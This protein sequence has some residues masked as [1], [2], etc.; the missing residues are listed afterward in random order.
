MD[1]PFKCASC[2]QTQ[3][4]DFAGWKCPLCGGVLDLPAPVQPWTARQDRQAQVGAL[5]AFDPQRID[6]RERGLWR[7]RHTLPLPPDAEPV[8]LGEGGTPLVSPEVNGRTVH[9][10]LEYLNPTG[11]FKDRGMA[12]MLTAL[13]ASGVQEAIE[14]SS[15][16]AGAS[17]AAYAARAGI[18]ARVFVPAT[19]A[20]PKR[21][22]IAA[23]G[24]E[25]VAVAG[26]RS[27]AAEAAR[28]AADQGARYASHVYNPL[29]LAGHATAAYEIWEQLSRAPE[30]V[31]LPLGHGTLLLG[32]HRGF[33]ALRA[34]GLIE[35]LPRLV[36]VQAM[37]CA[38]LWAVHAYGRDGLSW[39]TEG[40]TAAEG[41]RVLH[42]VRGDA[43]LAAIAESGGTILAVDDP[44]L[45]AGRDALARL[46]FYVEATSAVVWEALADGSDPQAR[47]TGE[48]LVI[49][50]GSGL[51]SP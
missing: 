7:Y 8:T 35:R 16:N 27:Q 10:K 30:S 22:Q 32:L 51:K 47:P 34:A 19:A 9:F 13:K 48:V 45:H 12:V 17:F 25:V 23:Y 41:I 28:R 24:A 29:A 40:E 42:P 46:G 2:G 43:V 14:D 50:T 49:L 38:P 4:F 37:A 44:A 6:H 21:A 31:V 39:V 3:P 20:G 26:P 18:K 5:P 36:G 15:G 1:Q 33:K 11:S